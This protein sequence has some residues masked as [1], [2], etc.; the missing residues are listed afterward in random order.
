[1]HLH[2]PILEGLV[3]L[4]L[5]QDALLKLPKVLERDE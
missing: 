1:L 4:G 5:L 3:G 2:P